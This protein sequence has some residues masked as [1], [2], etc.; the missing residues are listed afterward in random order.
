LHE[1]SRFPRID[2]GIDFP[3]CLALANAFNQ[4]LEKHRT[5]FA[6]QLYEF[7]VSR[8]KFADRAEAHTAECT[9]TVVFR[10]EADEKRF[11]TAQGRRTVIQ[12]F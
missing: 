3:E 1:S 2:G 4:A 5:C 9:F 8:S 11:D 7:R 12:A 10:N 6:P